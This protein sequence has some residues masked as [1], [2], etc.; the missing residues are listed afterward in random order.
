MLRSIPELDVYVVHL[1]REPL[2]VSYS[3]CL[4]K[5]NP[6]SGEIMGGVHPLVSAWSWSFVNIAIERMLKERRRYMKLSY[7]EFVADPASALTRIVAF[8]KEERAL[9]D[10]VKLEGQKVY[11]NPT[12]SVSGNPMRFTSGLTEIRADDRW[13]SGLSASVA[14]AIRLLTYPASRRY[15]C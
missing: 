11:L 10:D 3:R 7:E 15:R 1:I 12:H 2:G 13:K 8:V 9:L 14:Y 4:T 6:A 5:V